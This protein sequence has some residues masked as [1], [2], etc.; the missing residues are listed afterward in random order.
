MLRIFRE[1]LQWKNNQASIDTDVIYGIDSIPES[2]CEELHE[3]RI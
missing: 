2:Y 3:F 1:K